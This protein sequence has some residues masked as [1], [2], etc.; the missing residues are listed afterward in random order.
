MASSTNMIASALDRREF[1][2]AAAATVLTPALSLVPAGPV[3]A[4][5]SGPQ[6]WA[7][8]HVDDQWSGFPRYGEP[9]GFGRRDAVARPQVH[10]AD[11]PFIPT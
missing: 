3:A 1:L 10:P 5:V 2:S 8:W 9:I 6:L 4:A 11:E 7:D